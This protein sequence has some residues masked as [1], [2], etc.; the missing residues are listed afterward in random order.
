MSEA[1]LASPFGQRV[2]PGRAFSVVLAALV[3]LVLFAVLLFGVRWQNRPP[4]AMEVE[5][6]REPPP[7]PPAPVVLE[8]PKPAPVV[9]PEP[10]KPE[11]KPEPVIEKPDIAIKEPPPAPPKPEV[12]PKPPEPVAKPKPKPEPV[13]KPK[14][15]P[16]PVAKPKP[17]PKALVEAAAKA[18]EQ[19]A[20]RRLREELAREQLA[21]ATER[22]RQAVKDQL[23]RD[24][25]TARFNALA[26]WVGKVR[27]RIRGNIILPPDIK[28][29][30]E[31][32]FDVVQLPT[33]EVI[34]ANLRKSSGNKLLDDAIHRAILKSSPLP[35]PD[36]PDL[37]M[38]NFELKYRPHD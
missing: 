4:E 16:E 7:P 8:P 17:E 28:G 29:N 34:E 30:P 23:A 11:P 21:F 12:K 24:A 33:G 22:E 36:K 27:T 31:A 14:P 26:D 1:V 3:H 37:F 35:K 13:A 19:E 38:R 32:I 15:K 9:E 18:R 5:L 20:Q 2:D 25:A 10:P 6:W